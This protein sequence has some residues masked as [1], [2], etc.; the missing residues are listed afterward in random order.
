MSSSVIGPLLSPNELLFE[1]Q[2]MT[3][4]EARR[5]WR[6]AIKEA[7]NNSC[8]YCGTP[9]IDNKSLT[10]DHVRA[11]SNG[12]EDRT[13]NCIPACKSCNHAKG[14]SDWLAWYRMQPFH[15]LEAEMRIRHWLETGRPGGTLI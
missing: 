5:L 7:W 6:A 12:G 11:K 1:M 10:I 8:A 4:S 14:S 3:S 15:S 2:A 13:A 9:P